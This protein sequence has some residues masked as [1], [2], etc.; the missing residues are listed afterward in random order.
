MCRFI[1]VILLLSVLGCLQ[2]ENDSVKPML[3]SVSRSLFVH[4]PDHPRFNP[5]RFAIGDEEID[6]SVF[7]TELRNRLAS[8]LYDRIKLSTG[9]V[10]D[11]HFEALVKQIA[12]ENQTVIELLPPPRGSF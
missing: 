7:E 10:G 4:V 3:Q 11:E 8:R 12:A 6:V 1:F 9:K 5:G 2:S